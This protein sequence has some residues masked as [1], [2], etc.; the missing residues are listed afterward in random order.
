MMFYVGHPCGMTTGGCFDPHC[1]SK[2]G[3]SVPIYPQA[4]P[5]HVQTKLDRA[6]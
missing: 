4:A 2:T 1:P 6:P 5:F 3:I